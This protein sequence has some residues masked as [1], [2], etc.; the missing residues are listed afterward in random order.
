MAFL[1]GNLRAVDVLGVLHFGI[2]TSRVDGFFL[3]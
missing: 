3:L 2:K 1:L